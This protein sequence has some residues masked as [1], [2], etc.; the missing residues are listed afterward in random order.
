MEVIKLTIMA[1]I[2]VMMVLEIQ[3]KEMRMV[4]VLL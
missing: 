2:M 1:E 4:L 3:V